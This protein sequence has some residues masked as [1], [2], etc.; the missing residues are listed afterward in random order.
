MSSPQVQ[1]RHL[2]HPGKSERKG[3]RMRGS[4]QKEKGEHRGILRKGVKWLFFRK[5]RKRF[6]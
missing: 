5:F 3:S 6:C 4:A 1:H 2:G